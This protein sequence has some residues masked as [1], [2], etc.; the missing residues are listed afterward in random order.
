MPLVLPRALPRGGTLG[1]CSPAGPVDAERLRWGI[2]WLESE[3]FRVVCA[4]HVRARC[5][6]LAGDDRQRLEDF[7]ALLRDPQVHAIV[8]S[9]GGYGTARWL[10]GLD[11]EE[12]RAVRKL[13]IGHSDA[14]S[15]ALFLRAR[16]GLGSIHGPML[17]RDDL[18]AGARR[19]LL[20]LACGEPEGGAPLRGVTVRAGVATG[21][22]VGGNLT[23]L[24]S[25]LAT[26]WEI[27]TR[28]AV[29]FLEDVSEQP[30]A[31][32]RQLQQLRAAG[33]LDVLAGVA[34]GHFVGCDSPRY[35]EVSAHDVL[36]E[37]LGAAFDGP[38]V[39]DLSFGHIADNCALPIGP[40]ARL[41]GDAGTLTLLETAVETSTP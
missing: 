41:D 7:L 11:P 36:A 21:P 24:T 4:P 30:Y 26:P 32:D 17:Q 40:R 23:L 28:G 16:A 31:I 3:G 39:R 5:G 10:A 2:D 12:L 35:P 19:R 14:T 25:S 29:L 22:L 33:K 38:I 18:T 9:R 1:I 34:L 20:A 37:V 13:V 6:Y 15:L 8:Y 27:D